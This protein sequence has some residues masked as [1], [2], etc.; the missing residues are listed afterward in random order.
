MDEQF[1]SQQLAAC[2]TV[3]R[4]KEMRGSELFSLA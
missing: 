3:G 2:H 4:Y 1:I